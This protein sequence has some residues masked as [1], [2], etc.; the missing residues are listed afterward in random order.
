MKMTLC[1]SEP[2]HWE[3]FNLPTQN[4]STGST[5]FAV[6]PSVSYYILSWS[7]LL[8]IYLDTPFITWFRLLYARYIMCLLGH[9]IVVSTFGVRFTAA[10]C[11]VSNQLDSTKRA[12]HHRQREGCDLNV[13]CVWWNVFRC[14][15]TSDSFQS[16]K[17]E[18]IGTD[19][20]GLFVS[21]FSISF[22]CFIST[23]KLDC[24][25]RHI[26]LDLSS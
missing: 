3:N 22:W 5:L 26:A 18:T 11:I 25:E 1:W 12:Y 20:S 7:G 2:S 13:V 8:K 15:P 17:R 14:L 21:R 19:S 24:T 16:S 4:L 6:T 23:P 9:P 10:L